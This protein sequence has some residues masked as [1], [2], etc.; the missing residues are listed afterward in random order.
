MVSWRAA[1]WPGGFFSFSRFFSPKRGTCGAFRRFLFSQAFSSS[2]NLKVRTK[3]FVLRSTFS[4]F[5]RW[6]ISSPDDPLFPPFCGPGERG[7]WNYCVSSP[8]V[9]KGWQL[10]LYFSQFSSRPSFFFF[11]EL[12]TCCSG[13]FGGTIPMSSFYNRLRRFFGNPPPSIATLS[14]RILVI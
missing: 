6:I 3:S 14:L 13:V 7:E 12:L 9:P 5:S 10:R 4:F 8:L 11:S 1:F 2:P